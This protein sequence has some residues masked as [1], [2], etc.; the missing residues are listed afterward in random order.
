[1]ANDRHLVMLVD[2]N[3]A[4]L[5]DA[6][7][8]LGNYYDIC[9]ASSAEDM[10]EM[11]KV[12][13]PSLILIDID[14]SGISG[15]EAAEMLLKYPKTAHIPVIFLVEKYNLAKYQSKLDASTIGYI[16]KPFFGPVFIKRIETQ[17]FMT[18]QQQAIEHQQQEF[19]NF[20]SNL[21]K[22]VKDMSV[23]IEAE[24]Q[25]VWE[26]QTAVI[27]VMAEMVECR[28]DV[29]GGHI[30]RTRRGVGILLHDIQEK[31]IY[32]EQM[33]GWNIE[34]VL[35]ASQLHDVGKIYISDT[36][37]QKP[38]ELTDEEFN[39][40]K[41]HT[42]YGNTIIDRIE[43]YT[44]PNELTRHAKIFAGFHHEKWDGTGYP[45]GLIGQDIPLQG[46]LMAVADVYDALISPRPYK[47]KF[48]HEKA[49]SIIK[50]GKGTHFDP[51]LT[52]VFISA[53]E[54][55]RNIYENVQKGSLRGWGEI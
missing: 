15:F 22:M 5:M 28:D 37:L 24:S 12:T 53:T 46:R 9:T 35:Q 55:F 25:R 23:L 51:I 36:I 34:M 1:M 47:G 20:S 50:D 18:G 21:Q 48:S 17:L 43:A 10:I 31:H 4:S 32:M 19:R 44:Q 49:V 54:E 16:C 8:I 45:L 3:T 7:S 13:H 41:K 2:N 26:L 30:E 39:I 38:G 29:T 42:D 11:L 52:E 33:L 6:R 27:S 14:I 40:M